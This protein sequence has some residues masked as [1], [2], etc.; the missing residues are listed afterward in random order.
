MPPKKKPTPHD[1][2]KQRLAAAVELIRIAG[3]PANLA[4]KLTA[5]MGVKVTPGRV[6]K[7]VLI[8][9]PPSWGPILEVVVPG[10]NREAFNPWLYTDYSQDIH[11]RE[12]EYLV[13]ISAA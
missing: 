8:G 7:W 13:N 5:A 3:G 10:A 12:I 1:M 2:H 9:V 11:N 4:R 6:S